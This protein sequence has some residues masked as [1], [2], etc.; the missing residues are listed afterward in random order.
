MTPPEDKR[1][2]AVADAVNKLRAESANQIID[3]GELLAVAIHAYMTAE[4]AETRD[5]TE[6]V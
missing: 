5:T 6:A 1:Q 2:Q 4:P 3:W